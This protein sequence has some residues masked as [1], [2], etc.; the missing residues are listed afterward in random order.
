MRP[1]GTLAEPTTVATYTAAITRALEVAGVDPVDILRQAQVA[2]VRS[3]DPLL[4]I[5]DSD[6]NAIYERAVAATG[7]PCFGLKVADHILPGMLHAL[8]YALLAS[9]TLEDF[10]QR[11]VRYWGLVAQGVDLAVSN[12]GMELR[13]EAVPQGDKV[14]FET[15]DTFV[16]LILRL[17][18]MAYREGLHPQTVSGAS[19]ELAQHNDQI[20][21]RYLEKLDREISHRISQRRSLNAAGTVGEVHQVY[22]ARLGEN[23]SLES[24][25]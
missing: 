10:C 3:I 18:R 15:E 13:L 11:M 5:T 19:R 16:A 6:I 2:H 23:S 25:L 12:D 22:S 21:M 24:C 17:M 9:E 4:R 14:C 20:V 8:G 1:P 7:D